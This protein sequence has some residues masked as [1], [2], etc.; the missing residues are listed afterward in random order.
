MAK[1]LPI[2]QYFIT[3][4]EHFFAPNRVQPG[5]RKV[6]SL[7]LKRDPAERITAETAI[8]MLILVLRAPAKWHQ[9][10]DV[11]VENINW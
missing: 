11:Q 1:K 9:G 8:T 7:L 4:H 3:E 10:E 2:V 6:V 5:V